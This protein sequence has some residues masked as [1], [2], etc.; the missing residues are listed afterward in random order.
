MKKLI[1]LGL[2]GALLIGGIVGAQ[3]AQSGGTAAA[4]SSDQT[5]ATESAAE[6]SAATNP[7]QGERLA[8]M[9][10][11]RPLELGSTV[12]VTFYDGDPAADGSELQ[13]LEFVYGED[14][15]AAFASDLEAAAAEASYVT[16][17]TSPQTATYNLEEPALSDGPGHFGGFGGR[18]RGLGEHGPGGFGPMGDA[19]GRR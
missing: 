13:T 18:E 10:L 1:V 4:Q 8:R 15:E 2:S 14:S 6:T 19:G 12:S 16:V 7:Q 5:T 3:Q 9:L 11:G 17:T